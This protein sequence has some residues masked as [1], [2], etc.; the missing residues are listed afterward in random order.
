MKC[1]SFHYF[2]LSTL[3]LLNDQCVISTYAFKNF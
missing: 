3:S 2:I 1:K